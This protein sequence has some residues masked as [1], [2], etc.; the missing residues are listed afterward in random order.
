M[1]D[2]KPCPFCGS[3]VELEQKSGDW[4]YTH[5]TIRIYCKKCNVGFSAYTEEWE[6]GRGTYSIFIEATK[7]VITRWNSR[8]KEIEDV[9]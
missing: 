1:P 8:G 5:N 6:S 9:K 3:A 7:K 2:I 4:G